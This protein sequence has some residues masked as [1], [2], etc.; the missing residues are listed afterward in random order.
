MSEFFAILSSIFRAI[1]ISGGPGS[2]LDDSA[3]PFDESIFGLG[4]PILGE[5]KGRVARVQSMG[6]K[7][8]TRL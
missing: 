1:I 6:F 8:T 7:I 3:P 5:L 4:I 2:V